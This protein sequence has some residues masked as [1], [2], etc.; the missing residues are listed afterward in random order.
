MELYIYDRD[1][2]L[3]GVIDEINSLIWTRRYWSAGEFKLLVPFTNK[4]VSLLA[5]NNLIMKRGDTEAAEI[6]YVHISKNSQGLEE[7]EVQGKFITQ[8]IGKRIEIDDD[9]KKIVDGA[10]EAAVFALPKTHTDTAE[11]LNT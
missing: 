6:R 9:L 11:A 3:H 7:I 8:W 4:H 1:M 5:K 2:I 10:I